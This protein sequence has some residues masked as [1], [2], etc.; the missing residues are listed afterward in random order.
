VDFGFFVKIDRIGWTKFLAR[1]APSRFAKIDAVLG[2]NHILQGNG[3]WVRK[4][5]GLSLAQAGIISIHNALGAFFCT[6]ATGN[7][8]VCVNVTG[9]LNNCY[10]KV[11][12]CARQALHF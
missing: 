7:T 10:L 3:L 11:A 12:S 9:C 2:I 5:G 6:G 1:L 4:I 8:Q